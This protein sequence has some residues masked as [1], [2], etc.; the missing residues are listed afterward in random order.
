LAF[1]PV[2]NKS[3][4]SYAGEVLASEIPDQLFENLREAY[5]YIIVDLP[6]VAPFADAQAA[7]CALDSFI[8]VIEA[9]R[10]N[11]DV[12]KRGID[13]VRHENVIGIVLNKAKG[14]GV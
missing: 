12:V 14:D 10:T 6:A 13:V 2:G 3:R 9:S 8:F 5:D 11:I 4:P 1:L 7:V